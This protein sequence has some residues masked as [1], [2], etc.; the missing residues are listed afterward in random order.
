MPQ[1]GSGLPYQLATVGTPST[2]SATVQYQLTDD[3]S[4]AELVVPTSESFMRVKD[5]Y[6]AINVTN[7]TTGSGVSLHGG[8]DFDYGQS[9]PN[10]PYIKTNGGFDIYMDNANTH[11][12]S[13]FRVF[14]NTGLAGVPP[15]EELL[16]LSDNG[17]LTVSG[18]IIGGTF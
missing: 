8:L 15:G 1:S 14:K 4:S 6:Y 2:A 7:S 5:G 11:D 3:K 17:D 18:S 12:N 13:E 10:S 16:T 9:L